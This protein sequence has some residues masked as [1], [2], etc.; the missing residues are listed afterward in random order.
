MLSSITLFRYSSELRCCPILNCAHLCHHAS[1]AITGTWWRWIDQPYTSTRQHWA[2]WA[3]LELAER[4][5]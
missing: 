5:V 3:R 4:Q 1:G 2:F